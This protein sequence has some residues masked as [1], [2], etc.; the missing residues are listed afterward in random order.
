MKTEHE[1][2][3]ALKVK[4]RP[5]A[6]ALLPHVRNSTGYPS[7]TRTADALVMSLYPSRGL[8]LSG[9]EIKVS[10]SDWLRELKDPAKA[11]EI[12]RHCDYWW[13]VAGEADLVKLEELPPS[14]GLLV[15]KKASKASASVLVAD[16]PALVTKREATLLKGK[17]KLQDGS[18]GFLA[19]IVREIHD[20]YVPGAEVE[21]RV[22]AGTK[23]R[24]ERDK[25]GQLVALEH[26][27]A[28]LTRAHDA[29]RA[30]MEAFANA[31]GIQ[32]PLDQYQGRNV[33][34]AFHRFMQGEDAQKRLGQR[35]R[36]MQ[37]EV[38]EVLETLNRVCNDENVD[39]A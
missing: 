15:P 22:R 21:E 25:P 29:M 26:Q 35:L 39:P 38:R 3:A 33:G 5:P 17:E 16:V 31:S 11:E 34:E 23:E 13:I 36:Y 7:V 28:S 2:I 20:T 18:R 12:A 32:I 8:T 9:F 19:S 14:W 1:M 30:A 6:Y 4:Y 27:V 10:R 37:R 24:L